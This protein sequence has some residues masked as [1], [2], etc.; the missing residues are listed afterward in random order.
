MKAKDANRLKGLEIE[1]SELVPRV[2]V[3]HT[4]QLFE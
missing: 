2:E 4:G 1:S 3:C